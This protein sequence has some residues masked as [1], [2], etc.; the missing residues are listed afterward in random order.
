M[1]LELDPSFLEG[2]V[3]YIT[4]SGGAATNEIGDLNALL[5]TLVLE[6]RGCRCGGIADVMAGGGDDLGKRESV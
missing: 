6:S 4:G 1:S 3:S 2:P 5:G